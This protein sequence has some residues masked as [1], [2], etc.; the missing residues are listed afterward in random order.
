LSASATE[1]NCIVTVINNRNYHISGIGLRVVVDR[2]RIALLMALAFISLV[3]PL[4]CM[5][6]PT[7]PPPNPPAYSPTL[8]GSY[9]TPGN[10]IG[11]FVSGS[12]AYV[13]DGAG[14]MHIIDVSN[15][16][17]PVKLSTYS[18]L[19]DYVVV[20]GN[21]AY[22]GSGNDLEIVNVSDPSNP[23]LLG[24]FYVPLGWVEGIV[25]SGDYAYVAFSDSGLK[26][27][28]I[29][30]KS[31]PSL[32]GEFLYADSFLTESYNRPVR[33]VSVSGN[34]AY[35]GVD[36]RGFLTIDVSNPTS[37][38]LI[39]EINGYTSTYDRMWVLDSLLYG[40]SGGK[41]E[42]RNVADPRNP[43]W[44]GSY[45]LPDY[46]YGFSI[47]DGYAFVA[48]SDSGLI[49]IDLAD[50]EAPVLGGIY[51]TSGR[52]YDVFAS[53]NYVYVAEGATGLTIWEL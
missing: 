14:G 18:G 36:V 3:F 44:V 48:D 38:V 30:D 45:T 7:A 20:Y 25:V 40:M 29:S 8:V 51:Q 41:I 13:T 46:A 53:G 10:A 6:M 1:R 15:P 4:G 16:T 21:Y 31:N 24:S 12:L 50:L 34:Y 28:N 23:T 49:I 5:Q 42:V 9:D 39:T 52:A 2:Q 32:A 26:V 17:D 47:S 19:S 33:S 22:L 27:I 35:V 11:I 43:S 37:P